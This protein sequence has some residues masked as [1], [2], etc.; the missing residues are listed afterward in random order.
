[1][2]I[3]GLNRIDALGT[4]SNI[5][6]APEGTGTVRA[7][8]FNATS[9]TAGGFQGIQGDNAS[10]PSFTF[11]GDLDTGMFRDGS[12]RLGFATGGAE[13]FQVNRTGS[14]G[15]G[16]RITFANSAQITTA[17]NALQLNPVGNLQLESEGSVSSNTIEADTTASAANVFISGGGILRR[18]T[19]SIKY[20]TEVEESESIFSE[21]LVYQSEPV[22]YRSLCDGDPEEWSY[23]GFIAE[24]VAQIDPR[25]VHWGGE[26]ND[27]PEGVQ[28]DRY[29]VHLVKVAQ[30]QK[31]RID[32]L[33]SRIA[34]L[35]DSQS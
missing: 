3:L 17:A 4:D 6:L 9:T 34:A 35:E 22:W 28:Y 21:T 19:S 26:N 11:S 12:D 33:E 20:K 5:T 2:A 10:T 23:W 16:R 29:V 30:M 18:S 1:M 13:V 32:T 8:T 24:E 31:Q 7:P 25:M 15:S 27:E 14:F